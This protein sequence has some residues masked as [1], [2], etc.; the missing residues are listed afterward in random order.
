MRVLDALS[1]EGT[2]HFNLQ[3]YGV[4]SIQNFDLAYREIQNIEKQKSS[5]VHKL[6]DE[7]WPRGIILVERI[8]MA[9]EQVPFEIV[10][11]LS[12]MFDVVGCFSAMCMYDGAFSTYEDFFSGDLADQIYGFCFKRGEC[13]INMDAEVLLSN[14]WKSTIKHCLHRL[15]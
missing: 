5:K 1:V 12:K 2:S 14:E 11:I 13:V 15:E 4:F 7:H 9:E 3:C 6:F 8:V 10:S